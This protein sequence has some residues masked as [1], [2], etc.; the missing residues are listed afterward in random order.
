MS[1]LLVNPV[2]VFSIFSHLFYPWGIVLQVLALI[3][4]ARRRPGGFWIWIIL[5]G[6]FV[7]AAVYMVV[8][9]APDTF[10]L[11]DFFKGFQRRSRIGQLETA[12]IDNPSPGNYEE[13][14]DL[15]LEQK[16]YAQAR[17]NYDISIAAR[18]D[19]LDPFYRRGLCSLA[20][21][22]V[23]RALADL[24]YV[25]QKDPRYDHQRAAGLLAHA[26]ALSGQADKADALFQSVTQTSNLIE[27]WH[28]Y[29]RFLLSQNRKTEARE[30]A[31]KIL[32]KKRTM[33]RYLKRQE[34]PW[35]RKATS[36]IKETSEA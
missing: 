11:G 34:R 26:Y 31:Q 28:N 15:L 23:P 20:L 10:M 36:L 18:A 22:D 13:L 17:E 21:E 1:K 33:P 8:E 16:Q 3:H 32:D 6:G 7:G 19:T 14:G 29:A 5:F 35:F 27:T 24:E 2:N 25:Y 30:W 4:V 12:I 9:V